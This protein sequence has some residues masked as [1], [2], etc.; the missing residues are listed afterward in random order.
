MSLAEQVKVYIPDKSIRQGYLSLCREMWRELIESR[1]LI[2]QLFKRNFAAT[3]RQ[4]ILGI[5]WALIVPLA[6]VATFMLLSR[7]GIFEV[8]DIPV[9]YPL[10]AVAGIA[11]WQIFSL[12]L[13]LSANSL[14]SAGSMVTRL[15]FAKESLIISA[16]AQGLVPWLLQVSVVLVLLLFRY[17]SAPPLTILL[18]PLATIPLILLTLGL[19]LILSLVN[20]V[21]RDAANGI[22]ILVTF[23]M[24]ATPILYAKPAT[25]LMAAVTRY[26][27]L[28]Y[29]VST[30]RDLLLLGTIKDLPAF[31]YS[32]AF[33]I[34][35]FGLCWMAF[36][37]TETKVT[38]RI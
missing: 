23:L 1:W 31:L 11:F 35:V 38:E 25:G 17:H 37:L 9:P 27:P 33:S 2:L 24:F 7:G 14:I 21:V 10:Y 16:V 12:G 20:A 22:S 34:V 36:H 4:S 13:T 5:F 26:N 29:L 28:Y 19:G 30:P 3:Y 8:G 6:S 18:L 32:T 15:S